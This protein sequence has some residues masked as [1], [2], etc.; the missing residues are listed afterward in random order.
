MGRL[1]GIGVAR[2]AWADRDNP[3]GK[4][5][6]Y[7]GGRGSRREPHVRCDGM[8]YPSAIPIFPAVE[9]W[10]DDDMAKWTPSGDPSVHWNIYLGQYVMLL[11]HARDAKLE[12]GGHLRLVRI[13][14]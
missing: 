8:L 12:S 2:L 10:H 4:A 14:S 1:Q 3:V 7:A 11:N 13:P 6:A 5:M 9:P